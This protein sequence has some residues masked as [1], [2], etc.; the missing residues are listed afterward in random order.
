METITAIRPMPTVT[1]SNR[2]YRADLR[3]TRV[4]LMAWFETNCRNDYGYEFDGNEIYWITSIGPADGL[5]ETGSDPGLS[6]A[7]RRGGQ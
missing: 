2:Y 4:A 6:I 3:Q 7:L 5:I 1:I